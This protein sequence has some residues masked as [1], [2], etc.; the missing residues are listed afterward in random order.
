MYWI[1]CI[2]VKDPLENKTVH[3]E[4]SVLAVCVIY[5]AFTTTQSKTDGKSM[6]K[7]AFWLLWTE[8]IIRATN[9][10]IQYT[11]AYMHKENGNLL[12]C[13]TVPENTICSGKASGIAKGWNK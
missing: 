3:L 13:F 10:T 5:G 11:H 12:G 8:L 7:L 4:G 2:F 1:F 9:N 6:T